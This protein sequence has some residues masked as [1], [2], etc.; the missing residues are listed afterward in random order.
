MEESSQVKK[1]KNKIESF[2]RSNTPKGS[3]YPT[4]I[5][6]SLWE[7]FHLSKEESE[8]FLTNDEMSRFIAKKTGTQYAY[9]SVIMTIMNTHPSLSRIILS[10][11]KG[12]PL[13]GFKSTVISTG[14]YEG[15][16]SKDLFSSD[17]AD[18]K[19]H[20]IR[21]CDIDDAKTFLKDPFDKVRVEAYHRVGFLNCAEQMAKD[22]SS[23]IRALICQTLPH[24]HPALSLMMNDRS[25][26]VFSLVLQKIDKKQIPL[27]LGSRHLKESFTK[28]I[29]NKRMNNLGE[30]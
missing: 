21:I 20:F 28:S 2:I 30:T 26:W 18:A 17:D 16:L 10:S 25:K 24:G 29:L 8:V 19:V 1:L 23:K 14:A 3:K 22:K 4:G 13:F 27:M 9:R 12:S 6:W 15:T 11:K 5:G 7:S